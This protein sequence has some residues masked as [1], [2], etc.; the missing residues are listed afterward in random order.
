[1]ANTGLRNLRSGSEENKAV[2]HHVF[3]YGMH[4]QAA[5]MI[6]YRHL[7]PSAVLSLGYALHSSRDPATRGTAAQALAEKAILEFIKME[8][9][10]TAEDRNYLAAINVIVLSHGNSITRR[11]QHYLHELTEAET[12]YRDV[13]HRSRSAANS[14]A[15]VT[16]VWKSGNA[17]ILGALGY[18]VQTVFPF[19]PR[20]TLGASTANASSYLVG[21]LFVVVGKWVMSLVKEARMSRV[22]QAY[23]WRRQAAVWEYE[24]GKLHDGQVFHDQLVTLW[25]KYTGET[26]HEAPSY[27]GVMRGDLRSRRVMDKRFAAYSRSPL[28]DVREWFNVLFKRKE[29]SSG[30]G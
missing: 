14:G 30:I 28:D 20:V 7:D 4:D 8:P 3:R 15:V 22:V 5:K 23:T 10:G 11:K 16:L 9:C 19:L 1:M 12:Q 2:Q 24:E 13:R 26:Y 21:L 6:L 29:A 18:F 27:L 17:A 25:E